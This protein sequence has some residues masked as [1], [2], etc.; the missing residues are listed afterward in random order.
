MAFV[1]Q[2]LTQAGSPLQRSHLTAFPVL[3]SILTALIGQALVHKPQPLHSSEIIMTAPVSNSLLIA[4]L[5]HACIQKAFSQCSQTIGLAIKPPELL[6]TVS[7]ALL[8]A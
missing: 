5:G 6:E 3:E 1:G 8:G 4:P 2:Y 7:K